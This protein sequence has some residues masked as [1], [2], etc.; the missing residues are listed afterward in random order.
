MSDSNRVSRGVSS[1]VSR[2][3]EDKGMLPADG[4]DPTHQ[5]AR[6]GPGPF[7]ARSGSVY[8]FQIR[9]PKELGGGR[10]HAPL[11]VSLG[12]RPAT[13]ARATAARLAGF[14]QVK[15][16]ELSMRKKA[17]EGEDTDTAQDQAD[18]PDALQA[19]AEVLGELKA[20]ARILSQEPARMTPEEERRAK[21]WHGLVDIAREVEKGKDGNSI[22]RSNAR[23]LAGS[24]ADELLATV[25]PP[26]EEPDAEMDAV[27]IPGHEATT[28][29]VRDADPVGSTEGPARHVEPA[30]AGITEVTATMPSIS[31]I[32]ED[33][34]DTDPDA[35]RRFVKRPA[36]QHP[37]FSRM[38]ERYLRGYATQAGK[39]SKDVAT[40]RMRCELFAELIGNHPVDTY[41]GADLQAYLDYLTYWPGNNNERPTDLSPWQIIE[42]NK[43]LH[44]QPLAM[45]SLREGYLSVVKRVIRFEMV[46]RGYRDPFSGVKLFYPRTAASTRPAQPLSAQAISNIFKTGL[47]S[48]LHD[49]TFLPLLG[50]L[51]GRRLGLLIYLTGND[52][53]EKYPDV[54]VASTSGLVKVDG[55]WR[56]VPYKTE[57]STTFFVLNRF[58]H[59][60]GFTQWARGKGDAFLFPHFHSLA[61]PSKSASQYMQ[62]LW[63]RAGIEPG[64]GE[65]FHSL[66]SGQIEELRDSKIDARDRRLQ[67]GHSVGNDQHDNYGFMSITE[68]RAREMARLP[69]NPEIDYSIFRNLDFEKMYQA[70]RIK[71]QRRKS[72]G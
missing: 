17:D 9:W 53:R 35:D 62:R 40:A 71:G 47:A 12:A 51:T 50:N 5:V 52:I 10:G 37:T 1:R 72:A 11:R 21:A 19:R 3:T 28:D 64:Q 24:Y 70:K 13:E 66:R 57:A 16:R 49:E 23:L 61:D 46:K 29:Q 69:L 55:S 4:T 59:D 44:L 36:S 25:P 41:E 68:T 60:I 48:G 39:G 2:A 14:A 6:R 20:Y 18:M 7:L 63:R 58:L 42:D 27:A 54:W 38:A 22:I 34:S 33:G 67:V 32:E 8:L 56:R 30:A 65:F 43:D 15:F 31:R 45:K 26:L